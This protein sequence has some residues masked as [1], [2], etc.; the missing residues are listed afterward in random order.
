ME[1]TTGAG[2][3]FAAG[4]AIALGEGRSLRE[5]CRFANGVASFGLEGPGISA[6]AT[7]EAV[8]QRIG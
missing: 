4:L 5:A 3:T 8:E 7:R 1:D 6:L 2:D